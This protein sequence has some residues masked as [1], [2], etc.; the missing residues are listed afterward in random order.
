MEIYDYDTGITNWISSHQKPENSEMI[1][2]L[3]PTKSPPSDTSNNYNPKKTAYLQTFAI[4][5]RLMLRWCG[6]L[7]GEFR[8]SGPKHKWNTQ[9]CTANISV[10]TITFTPKQHI[11]RFLRNLYCYWWRWRRLPRQFCQLS[12]LRAFMVVWRYLLPWHAQSALSKIE[13]VRKKKRLIRL[14]D[15]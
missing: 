12:P 11:N 13:L 9:I 10:A 6:T 14:R 2:K 7:V 8:L 5:Y 4:V 1:H 15:I 3:H